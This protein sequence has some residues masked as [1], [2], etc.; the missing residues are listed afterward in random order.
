MVPPSPLYS[1]ARVG[2]PRAGPKAG[3]SGTR[4]FDFPTPIAA[5]A[6]G[7]TAESVGSGT[8]MEIPFVL[9]SIPENK[10]I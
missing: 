3:Y 4:D 10:E 1:W 7:T 2:C 8:T 5:F 9:V 6:A